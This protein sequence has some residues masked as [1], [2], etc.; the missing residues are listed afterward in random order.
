MVSLFP[1]FLKWSPGVPVYLVGVPVYLGCV[2]WGGWGGR[3]GWA[4]L[5]KKLNVTP[6]EKKKNNLCTTRPALLVKI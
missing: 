6:K 3:G 2:G 4:G 1:W 5:V